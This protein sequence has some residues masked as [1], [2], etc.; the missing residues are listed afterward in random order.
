MSREGTFMHGEQQRKLNGSCIGQQ[1]YPD[2][3][4]IHIGGGGLRIT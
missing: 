2:V 3:T 1:L 4:G